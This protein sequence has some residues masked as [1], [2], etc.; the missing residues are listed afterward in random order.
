[1]IVWAGR[2]SVMNTLI[3]YCRVFYYINAQCRCYCTGIVEG[4]KRIHPFQGESNRDS[5]VHC[6]IVS[7]VDKATSTA[8]LPHPVTTFECLCFDI[9]FFSNPLP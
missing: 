8:P 7:A 1:M 5:A 2:T 9:Y 4:N 6:R 3:N